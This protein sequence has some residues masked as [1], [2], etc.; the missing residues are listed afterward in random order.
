MREGCR[1]LSGPLTRFPYGAPRSLP[2]LRRLT[3]RPNQ[4]RATLARD[5]TSGPIRSSR[6]R[7]SRER[8]SSS[9][10]DKLRLHRLMLGMTPSSARTPPVRAGSGATQI[11][12]RSPKM[13]EL[14]HTSPTICAAATRQI[15]PVTGFLIGDP[16]PRDLSVVEENGAAKRQVLMENGLRAEMSFAEGPRGRRGAQTLRRCSIT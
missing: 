14:L 4:E 6:R 5:T 15:G 3:S 12:R 10:L 2:P 9:T 1:L 7:A 8:W 11:V 16:G 13:C